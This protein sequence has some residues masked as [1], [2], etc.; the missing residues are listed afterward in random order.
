MVRRG[1]P[2]SP[3]G[4]QFEPLG[5]R[6]DSELIFIEINEDVWKFYQI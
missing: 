6:E 5:T 4:N 3:L 1:D 2:I